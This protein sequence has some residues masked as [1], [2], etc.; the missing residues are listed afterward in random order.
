MSANHLLRRSRP[1]RGVS[2]LG[3]LVFAVVIVAVVV[4]GMRVL[5]TA[6]EFMAAKRAIERVATS[7]ATDPAEIRKAF[8]RF[9]A[10][11]DIVTITGKDLAI[12]RVGDKVRV[13][14]GYEKRVP[15][16]GPASLLLDYKASAP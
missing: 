5:P 8:D 1:E 3:M 12:E 15:L 10:V 11:D 13:S 9:A 4:V 16:F 2:L 6:L 14:F 7:G